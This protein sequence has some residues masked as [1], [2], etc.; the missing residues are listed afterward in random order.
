MATESGGNRNDEVKTKFAAREGTYTLQV[1]SEYSRPTRS[2]YSDAGNFPVTV[3]FTQLSKQND[4]P[5]RLAFSI[6]RELY[7]YPFKGIRKV[8]NSLILQV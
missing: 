3:S 2:P 4:T 7:V 1:L 6:G 8:F 5:E